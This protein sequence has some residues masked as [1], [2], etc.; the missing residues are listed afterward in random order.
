MKQK[1]SNTMAGFALVETLLIFIIVALVAGV[2]YWVWSQRKPVANL[3][4]SVQE[5]STTD[6]DVSTSAGLVEFL[7]QNVEETDQAA[8]TQANQF[9]TSA[10]S[11]TAAV[12]NMGGAYD[13][14][15]F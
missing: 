11:D 8:D 13:A 10:L 2:G 6:T 12:T 1:Q 14:A 9:A 15:N 3:T 4:T 5:T 7:D